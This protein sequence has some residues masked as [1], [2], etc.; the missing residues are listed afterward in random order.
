MNNP[1]YVGQPG[2]NCLHGQKSSHLSEISRALRWDLTWVGWI[3]SHKNDLLLQSS[4]SGKTSHLWWF[5]SYKQLLKRKG[6][7]RWYWMEYKTNNGWRSELLVLQSIWKNN[8]AVARSFLQR[9]CS[10]NFHA[11]KS[12]CF[13]YK[14]GGWSMTYSTL[15]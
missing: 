3:R 11:R 4:Y 1:V 14:V 8:E 10:R 7:H 15:L 9:S 6:P 13:C 2:K 5:V 12:I